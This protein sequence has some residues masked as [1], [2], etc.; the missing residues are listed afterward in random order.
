ML[1]HGGGGGADGG[2][3]GGGDG[4]GAGGGGSDGGG[5]LGA[6]PGGH[7]GAGSPPYVTMYTAPRLSHA[8]LPWPGPHSCGAPI[9]SVC[10]PPSQL[11]GRGASIRPK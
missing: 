11:P 1:P 10:A 5:G 3:D 9:T 6:M 7:G 8:P 2:D 4:G